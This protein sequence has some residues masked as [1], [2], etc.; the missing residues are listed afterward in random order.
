LILVWAAGL[1]LVF[2]AGPEHRAAAGQGRIAVTTTDYKGWKNNLRLSNGDAELVVT[3]DVGPRI[4]HYALAGGKNVFKEYTQQLGKTGEKDWQIRGGHRLWVAPEDTTRTYAPDNGAVAFKDEGKG[5][6]RF[7]PTPETL[8]GIQKEMTVELAP[9]GSEVIVTHSI[10]NI[11][12]RPTSLAPWALSVMAPGGTEIIPL[13]PKRPHP[14][15]PANAQNAKD[16]APNQTMVIWPFFDFKDNRWTFG[17]R[18]IT[19]KQNPRRKDPTKI[20]L[21]HQ[22]GWVGYL[23]QG[24]LFVK[25]FHYLK[26]KT[27]PDNGCNFETFTN[28]D[29]L[30]IETLGPL[31]ELAPGTAVDLVERW[32]LI[33]KV[34]EFKGEAGIDLNVLPKV[35]KE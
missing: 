1:G 18:Y 27:Y 8:Y 10:K 5:R 13:P 30:E 11:G 15:P 19:L 14:G 22:M 25:R 7:I 33:P 9:S 20:G 35:K 29:M 16:F 3:L 26:G 34:E 4:I 21:A 31:T 2:V 24:T 17:N 6:V 28:E 23:N 32:E 12:D